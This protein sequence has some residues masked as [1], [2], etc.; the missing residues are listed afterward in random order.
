MV[1]ISFKNLEGKTLLKATND[2]NE[3]IIF[4]TQTG[5]AFE[6]YHEQDCCESVYV[7][8]ITGDLSDLLETPILLA[9]V[10][11]SQDDPEDIETSKN[12]AKADWEYNDSQTWT[13]YKLRTIKGSVD[14]RWLGTSNGYYSEE[15]SFRQ[16]T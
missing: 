7:E 4:E 3:R 8:S 10:A 1:E 15:V 2:N 5:E 12:A 9:E 11:S 16:V 14:I 13:F 6:L